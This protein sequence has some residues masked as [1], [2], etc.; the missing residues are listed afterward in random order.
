MFI[1]ET[2]LSS[3]NTMQDSSKSFLIRDLLSDLID[4]SQQNEGIEI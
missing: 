3:T 1:R 4:T 2:N